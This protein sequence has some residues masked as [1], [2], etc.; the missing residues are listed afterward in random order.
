MPPVFRQ[1]GGPT[2]PSVPPDPPSPEAGSSG[3]LEA[4]SSEVRRCLRAI[5]A[6]EAGGFQDLPPDIAE[7]LLAQ[8]RGTLRR[9]SGEGPTS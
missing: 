4:S 1:P 3:P 7:A 2:M 5:G 8:L 6:L 9:L